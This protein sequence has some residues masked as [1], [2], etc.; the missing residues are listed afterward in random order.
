MT[1]GRQGQPQVSVLELCVESPGE[2]H[3]KQQ[4]NLQLD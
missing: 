3:S 2:I 4:A 1:N